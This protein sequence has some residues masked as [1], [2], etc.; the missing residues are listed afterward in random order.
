MTNGRSRLYIDIN[1][2]S[3]IKFVYDH[4]KYAKTNSIVKREIRWVTLLN[5]ET[6]EKEESKMMCKI[7]K[8]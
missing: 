6:C 7:N 3:H 8:K 1:S 5:N 2:A 4:D